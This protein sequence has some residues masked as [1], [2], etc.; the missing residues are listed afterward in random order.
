[1][2]L[3]LYSYIYV[4]TRPEENRERGHVRGGA[5]TDDLVAVVQ[6]IVLTL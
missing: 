1:M 4:R 5:R 3:G 6:I 2:G